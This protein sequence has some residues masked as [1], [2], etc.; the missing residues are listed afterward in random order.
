M[1]YETRTVISFLT[2]MRKSYRNFV[3]D[4]HNA[5]FENDLKIKK[6]DRME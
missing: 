3:G 6:K 5:Q 2:I 4:E 1:L